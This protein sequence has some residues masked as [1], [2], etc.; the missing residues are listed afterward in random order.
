ME[1]EIDED[2]T[3]ALK[4]VKGKRSILKL[5]H[6]MNRHKTAFPKKIDLEK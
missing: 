3:E 6:K 2:Y 1:D 4:E 5:K